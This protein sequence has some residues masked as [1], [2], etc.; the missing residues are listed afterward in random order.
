MSVTVFMT[1]IW[2]LWNEKHTIVYFGE[3]H[4]YKQRGTTAFIVAETN[5]KV[6]RYENG[7]I[8]YGGPLVWNIMQL[9]K[10]EL[11]V[12]FLTRKMSAM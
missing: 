8:N 2:Y 4:V 11:N 12:H 10:N 7:F 5:T 1:V 3:S 6:R 9:L